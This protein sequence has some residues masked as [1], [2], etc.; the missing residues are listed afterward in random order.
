MLRNRP[1]R[2]SPAQ[3]SKGEP[4]KKLL[5]ALLLPVFGI[6]MMA[7]PGT[8]QVNTGQVTGTVTDTTGA[9]IAGATVTLRGTATGAERTVQTNGQGSFLASALTPGTYTVTITASGFGSYAAL[10]PVTVGGILTVDAKLG[11][12]ASRQTVL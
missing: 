8:A 12:Q 7:V 2:F 4:M 1:C 11:I 3:R 5:L 9:V 10:A 6:V